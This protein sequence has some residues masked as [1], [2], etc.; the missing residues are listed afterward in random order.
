[1]NLSF[2]WREPQLQTTGTS[3]SDDG[4]LSFRRRESQLQTTGI[5]AS[6]GENPIFSSHNVHLPASSI[7]VSVFLKR[8]DTNRKSCLRL[9]KRQVPFCIKAAQTACVLVDINSY[10]NYTFHRWA[11]SICRAVRMKNEL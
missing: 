4:N 7:T 1:M 2:R 6:D 11:S 9:R 3:A 8:C 5:S 10:I